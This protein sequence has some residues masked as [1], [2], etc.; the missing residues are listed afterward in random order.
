MMEEDGGAGFFGCKLG[1]LD[2]CGDERGRG[3]WVLVGDEA[4]SEGCVR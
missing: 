2:V 3:C 1:S 4:E